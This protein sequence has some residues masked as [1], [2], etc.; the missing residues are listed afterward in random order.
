NLGVSPQQALAQSQPSIQNLAHAAQAIAAQIAAQQSAAAAGAAANVPNGLA[1]G[2]LQVAP[3]VAFNTDGTPTSATS[4]LSNANLWVNANAP[5][6]SVAANGQVTVEIDQTA[7]SA[8]AT[9]QT[10]N[11]GSNTTLYFNQGGGT[12]TNGANNWVIL[13]RI[14]DPSGA[15]SQIFG[16]IDAQG[17]VYVINRNGIL[18]GA[19]SQVNVHTLVAS[20]MDFLNVNDDIVPTATDIADSNQFF[21]QQ[22]GGLAGLE[23]G[24]SGPASPQF[25]PSNEVLGLGNNV[26]VATSADYQVPGDVTVEAGASITTQTNGTVSDG[27]LVLL[28]GHNVTNAGQISATD[29][30]IVLAAGVGVALEKNST[31]P[32]VLTPELSGSVTAGGTDI[33]PVGTVTNSGLIQAERGN[34][35]LL[36]TNVY[37]N[38][39]VG[40]TTSVSEPGSITISTVDEHQANT[41]SGTAYSREALTDGS[42]S[43]ATPRAGQLVFGPGSVTTVLPDGDDETA[44][45]SPGVT[46]VTG[47]I[48]ASAGSIWLQSGSLIEA[49]GANV[50][51]SALTQSSVGDVTPPG[52]TA[53]QGRVYLDTGATIDVSGLANVELPI[54]DIL[55][56]VP[57]VSGNELAN[58]PL[59]RDSFL[60][61][62]QNLV[63]DSTLSGT[64]PDGSQWVGSPLLNLSGYVS[65]IPRSVDQLLTNGGTITLTGNEVMTASGSS[66]ALNGGYVHYLGGMV[67]TT[68][69]VDADGAI[70]PIGEASPYDT[71]IGVA[72]E[73]VESHPRW[74]VTE[75]WFNPL[76]S[77]G[78][79]EGDFI[80]GGTAG[81]LDLYAAQDMVLDGQISAQALAG[82]KQ[83]QGN[84]QPSGGTFN[85]G[86]DP[87]LT[88]SNLAGLTLGLQ[89]EVNGESGTIVVQN[90]APSL[91]SLSADGSAFTASTPLDTAALNALPASDPDNVL[92]N[93]VVP[94]ETLT[95]GGFSTVNLTE[96]HIGG[97]GF[98]VEAGAVL[99]VQP[100]GSIKMTNNAGGPVDLLGSLIAPSGSI[101]IN[102]GSGTVVLGP[103]G[104]LSVAGEWINNDT[105]DAP[106]TTAGDSE[107][108]NGGTIVVTTQDAGAQVDPSIAN[109]PTVDSSGSI[110][111]QAGSL[112]DVSSGGEIQSNGQMLMSNGIAEG[113][114]GSLSLLTYYAPNGGDEFGSGGTAPALPNTEPTSGTIELDG[115]IRSYGFDGGGTLALQAL[116]FQIGG[117]PA[118]APSWAIYLPTSFF[119]QQGFGKYEL[120]AMYD[121]TIAPG[122]QLVVSQQNLIPNVPA[123]QGAASGS[124]ILAGG[125]TTLGTTDAYDRQPTDLQIT[126]GAYLSWGL[127][128][129]A[130]PSYAD[131]T[132]AVTLG[133]GASIIADPGASV[134]L[135]SYAQTTV[136]GSIYAPGGAITLTGDPGASGLTMLGQ[137]GSVGESFTSDSKSVWLGA[138]AVLDVAGVALSDPFAAPER[139]ALGVV[140]P[141]T[142]KVLAGGSVTVVDD[143]GFVVAQ[144]GSTI[145]VSG[146]S[147]S[148]D[149]PEPSGLY[150]PQPA[151]SNAG[152]ITLGASAGLDFDGTLSA[153][154]GA[155]QAQ[156]GTL[157][158]LGEQVPVNSAPLP[159]G[160]TAQ[161]P[162]AEVLVLQQ[163]GGTVPAGLQP[164]EAFPGAFKTSSGVDQ[165]SSGVLVFSLDRLSGSGISTLVVD[166]ASQTG[167]N[168]VAVGF[169]GNVNASLANSI[170]IDTTQLVALS[171][172]DVQQLIGNGASVPI[173]LATLLAD[174]TG[175]TALGAP[176]LT[177]NAPYV[178]IEGPQFTGSQ[179]FTPVT[180]LGDGT[181]N[182]NASFIDLVNEFQFNNIAQANLTSSGDIRMTS[183]NPGA[184]NSLAPGE[185]VTSGNLTFTEADLYPSTG[186]TFI[187][188][189][190]GPAASGGGTLPTTVTF[191]ADGASSVPLT[192]GGTLLVDA[193][194]IVQAGNVR[195]P[196]G[197][198]IFGVG[199]PTDTA[200]QA[201]FNNL[202]LVATQS[203]TFES[204][205]VTSVSDAG[206]II[207]YGT[208]VDGI[209]WQFNPVDNVPAGPDLSAPPSKFI[210]AN[211]SSVALNAGATI[212][213]SGGGDLQAAEWVS[214]TGGT[215][216]LLSQYNVDY[217][218]TASGVAVPVNANAGNVYAIL[219]GKQAPV[220]PYDPIFAQ[221]VQPSTNANGT[222][223]TTTESSGVGNAALNSAVGESVYLSGVPGLAAGYYTLLPAKYATL[224]GA[225][226]VT[227]SSASGEVVPGSSQTLP[228]GT[229]VA[230]GYLGNALDG[231][232]SATPLLFDVQS[233]QVWQQYSQYTLTSANSFFATQAAQNGDVVPQLPMDGGQL[234][235]AATTQL[236]L[237]AALDAAAAP[238]GAPAEVDIASQDIQIV[239]NGE[240][241]SEAPLAGYLQISAD[242]LDTLGAGSLLI[243]GTRTQTTSG[244]T[245][246]AI[247]NSIVVSNDAADPLTGPEVMLVTKT[248][249]DGTDPN[250]ANG[251]RVDPGSVIEAQG[252]YPAA[253]DEPITIG[254]NGVAASGSTQAIA[255]ISG[256]GAFLA[257]TNG[258][259]AVVT[260]EDTSPAAGNAGLLTV[261]A[262]AQLVGGAALTLD[263]SGNLT[264]DPSASLSGNVIAVDGSTITFTNQTGAAAAGL[265]GFVVGPGQLAQLA[266][267]SELILRSSG[268]MDF[269]GNVDVNFV[270]QVELSAGV[271]QGDGGTVTI[272][273]PQLTL[274]NDL[275]A[276]D[277]GGTP[278]S[279]TLTID[280]GELE[281]GNGNASV[282]GFGSA[283]LNGTGAIVAAGNGTLDFGATPVTMSAPA[284]IA[285]TG[286]G[287]TVTT[288][289]ALDL[290]AAPGTA[291]SL[292]PLGGAFT[293][294]GGTIQDNGAT[295][296][297]PGG[298]IS[299]EATSGDLDIA[300]GSMLDAGGV[301]TPVFDTSILVPAGAISLTSDVGTVNVATGSTLNFAGASAG[302][303][304]GSLTLSAPDQTVNLN[305]TIE[306]GAAAGY[307]GGSFSLNTGGAV[308]LDGLA[309]E[310]ATS[311]VNNAIT[312]VTNAGNL[313]LSQGNTIAAQTVTL[314]ANG[315]AGNASDTANG[316]VII[317]G[318][319]NANGIAN[320]SGG[321]PGGTINLFG[322]SSV[323]VEGTLTAEG[324]DA[325]MVNPSNTSQLIAN[326]LSTELGG[327]INIGTTGTPT[328]GSYNAQYGYENVTLADSGKITLG[329][330]AKIDVSGGGMVTYLEDGLE[331]GVVNLRAPLLSD[332]ATNGGTYVNI[333]LAGVGNITGASAV[334]LQA[335]AVWSTTDS[336]T[337]AQHFDGYVDPAGW[338][339]DS[340]HLEGGVFTAQTPS[341]SPT[342]FNFTP[343]TDGDGGGTVTNTTTNQSAQL[344][345]AQLQTGDTAIGFGG[346]QSDYFTPNNVN[347]DHVGFY[348]DTVNSDGTIVPG[349]LMGYVENA[350]SGVDTQY[351]S[352][353]KMIKVTPGIELDNPSSTINGGNITILTDWNLGAGT[354][355]D[356]LL[357]RF[358]GQAPVITFRAEN[359]VEVD[360]SLSDGFFQV[361]NPLGGG[362][363]IGIPPVETYGTY[364]EAVALYNQPTYYAKYLGIS[365]GINQ[366]INNFGF[367]GLS[368]PQDIPGS[369]PS[370]P[371]E[372]YAMY[373]A[374]AKFLGAQVPLA[375]S[376]AVGYRPQVD[377]IDW[378]DAFQSGATAV[379][380]PS[381]PSQST[382]IT[383]PQSY[384][385]Y[386]ANY[387]S[388]VE[389][390]PLAD[391]P[392]FP[393]P[394]APWPQHDDSL[395][396][397]TS[398][399]IP[400]VTDNTPSPLRVADNPL[401]LASASLNSGPSS[402][403]QIVAGANFASANP[404]GLQAE[405]IVQA[406]A[407][408]DVNLNGHFEYLD[409][410]GG[411]SLAPTMIRTGTGA[412]YIAAANDVQLLDTTAPGVIYTAGTPAPGAPVG[413]NAS[414]L[415]ANTTQAL[416][417]LLVSPSVSPEGAGNISI[418]A[419]NDI[420]GIQQPTDPDG[421]ISGVAGAN[422]GQY[423]WQWMESGN[424]VGQNGNVTQ[425]SINFG[426]FDQ[427]VMSVGG[428]VTV[429]AGGNIT[430]L[431]V[432]L[433]TSWYTDATGATVTVGAGNLNVSAG[434]NILSGDYF[435]GR[436]KGTLTAGGQIAPDG[437]DYTVFD[438]NNVGRPGAE[439]NQSIGTVATLLGAQDAVFDVTARQGVDI[440]AMVDPSYVDSTDLVNQHISGLDLQPYSTTS[441]LV[442][443]STTGN[444]E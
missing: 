162:G 280:A 11:V 430:D 295:I 318:T 441:A 356:S 440:G 150:A 180:A 213:L 193:T 71:F 50:S 64:N 135:G 68:R 394:S 158:L 149:M 13:N 346:L 343:D 268:A 134:A 240:S 1:A 69:L 290:N 36:G 413:P 198:L 95:D 320:A 391:D 433:P 272:T 8:V 246:D 140:T 136:L 63:F 99:E 245:I 129:N 350:L 308:D 363:S 194:N 74:G 122:T 405:A 372:Y 168:P 160:G 326:P 309:S 117:D 340:G 306:G 20:A 41:P 316:N 188:D 199:D 16:H 220:A 354:S 417:A 415:G 111:L 125:L 437:S 203:V 287:S 264:F 31:N 157:T 112:I 62:F 191:E 77:G 349:T 392:I 29:G 279:G 373:V 55:V 416:P 175:N 319:I 138:N 54:A 294:V 228:D 236:S 197:S 271:F 110:D 249:P 80:V 130:R 442:V 292:D 283:A 181:L 400:A 251:L 142:G 93:L 177:L 139:T 281:L 210:S 207:P 273:A 187:L 267:A 379:S 331:G 6:Q 288:T 248:D 301:A 382:Q 127:L 265:P 241:S 351:A 380:L 263:S 126:A 39:V 238:G 367:T 414:L 32:Q 192:A 128:N 338:Y 202:P 315:G 323:D 321:N 406:A 17:S 235:L 385:V 260:R 141:D 70:V 211:G 436:G 2:G 48:T 347:S 393:F 252:S 225:F 172:N 183:T 22:T 368:G 395:T 100:G 159:G 214:G 42:N 38:G 261:G 274:S 341:G 166:G 409:T 173:T 401:P 40:V 230:T 408:G 33:T 212:D 329:A 375:L 5:K 104:V 299:M 305:G 190:V 291:P 337:G 19:G 443:T 171:S 289:A 300:S 439:V 18:F 396:G 239:G 355:Q 7:Q 404:L 221:T 244:I 98:T 285:G 339:D 116:G 66:L 163:S 53:V 298:N 155:A 118:Q 302:G 253:K 242:Q 425:A 327:T 376:Q 92:G 423:W 75:D 189:A 275:G 444:V 103:D 165:P 383:D 91:D 169:E 366:F 215:R 216:D 86:F 21:L 9:W 83:V 132:G 324:S 208:T 247:A 348:S 296:D 342:T 226:R 82:Q 154:P 377:W 432:S 438:L 357:Y 178:A 3:G 270:N 148:F 12:Q 45:S 369:T 311:G 336:T 109:G 345:A 101:T 277:T 237:G 310:L 359:N 333:D 10:M 89:T 312:I 223:S 233:A 179:T 43:E 58:S 269:D 254:Q 258:G 205:S 174:E 407:G 297:A 325:Y 328:A 56:T 151:W 266:N 57:T 427:G 65:L 434:G 222:V 186:S 96:D 37:Q 113:R 206:A 81:T 195:A 72:G 146:A 335:Y 90:S 120:N 352:V 370:V 421:S 276:P 30:Q 25:G 67:D 284:F 424:P 387:T 78:A 429:S 85:F 398:V 87:T 422:L 358:N 403:F 161:M 102:A 317:D 106:G 399:P 360:A 46:F 44:T 227:V 61:N 313:V 371:E 76:L 184:Q 49:P 390:T 365:Y 145:D 23:S 232:R 428:N 384:F 224:P 410:T 105:Q 123:L 418:Q 182:V 185:L 381:A 426:A 59:L 286:S 115:T 124:D 167:Q 51:L 419:Q 218:Q 353:L 362:G 144:A 88:G 24:D 147:A 322:N 26:S 133:A 170:V 73:F 217:S 307:T 153:Q 259:D 60:N 152:S 137:T 35:N 402:T 243:G 431:A 97:K 176:S 334:N 255:A 386:L 412:I 219:P 378:L 435:V 196:S 108:I 257:V 411:A 303:A 143:S 34:V 282:A 204:G 15:P 200:T 107:Y 28:A 52:D 278:G 14:V 250:A 229:V 293:F 119:S 256:D 121:A 234:V 314:T 262:G 330:G 420:I 389:S 156:G 114:G 131:V 397:V 332:G 231:S 364:A 47:S 201:Q 4:N 374:Y 27:G 84:D 94:A 79:Y 209:E 304:A 344:D 164:G 361:A 388:V